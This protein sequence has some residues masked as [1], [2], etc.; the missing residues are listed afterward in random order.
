MAIWAP[1]KNADNDH[2]KLHTSTIVLTLISAVGLGIGLVTE[3]AILGHMQVG[4]GFL[5]GWTAQTVAMIILA[6]KDASR[7]NFRKLTRHDFRWSSF[8]GLTNGLSGAFYV[9]AIFHADNVSLI[10]AFTALTVPLTV[11]GSYL[12]LHEREH[13]KLMWASVAISF[14]GLL[15]TGIQ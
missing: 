15:V 8:M 9:Y 5:A 2:R 11:F 1:F 4:G 14:I 12:F 6:G 13:Q 7:A 3:K 10:T